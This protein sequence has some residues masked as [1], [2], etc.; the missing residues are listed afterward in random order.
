MGLKITPGKRVTS[1]EYRQETTKTSS[2]K[3]KGKATPSQHHCTTSVEKE[4]E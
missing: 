3:K 2:K 4:S 1:L